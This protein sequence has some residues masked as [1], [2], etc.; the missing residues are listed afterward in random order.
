MAGGSDVVRQG[1]TVLKPQPDGP[2]PEPVPARQPLRLATENGTAVSARDEG[3]RADDDG[4]GETIP[5]M[6]RSWRELV[7]LVG[8]QKEARL[9]GTLRHLGHVVEFEPPRLVLRLAENDREQKRQAFRAL[10]ALLDR[11][12]PGRWQVIASEEQGEPTL[13]EQGAEIIALHQDRARQHPL[14]QA[15]MQRFPHAQIGEVR[16]HTL[17]DYGLPPETV[18]PLGEDVP[19]DFEFAP[20]DAD[21]PD[22][23]DFY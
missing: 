9:H 3:Q 22:E 1:S 7:A 16:D 6:P 21:Y 4:A 11:L 20:P 15:I 12:Y 14:V 5:P 23:D 2:A 8:Q 19:P 13:D 17:D 18:V 10:T